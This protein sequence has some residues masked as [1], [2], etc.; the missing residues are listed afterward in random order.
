[1]TKGL[2]APFL[3]IAAWCLVILPG[4]QPR[5][6]TAYVDIDNPFL[7]S[8]VESF[9]M[10]A[11]DAMLKKDVSALAN[12]VFLLKRT[13]PVAWAAVVDSTGTVLMHSDPVAI[14]TVVTDTASV[15]SLAYAD[16]DR[17][18]VRRLW[19]HDRRPVLDLT[20]PVSYGDDGHQ[21]AAGYVR[22]GFFAG[23][24]AQNWAGASD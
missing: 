19:S 14:A 6:D 9:R 22:V 12:Q 23:Q 2:M 18:L 10:S 24:R 1:M 21:V 3:V 11:R 13:L 8:T 20:L 17:P 7:I 4:C 15:E 5:H 16:P